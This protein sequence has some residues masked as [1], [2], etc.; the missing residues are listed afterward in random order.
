MAKTAY[1]KNGE[2]VEL[3]ETLESGQ[4]IIERMYVYSDYEGNEEIEP[5]GVKEVVKEV[6]MKPPFQK[7]HDDLI[8]IIK[9]NRA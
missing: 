1:L 7:K 5:C 6:F 4:F 3:H 9:K 8:K 2:T